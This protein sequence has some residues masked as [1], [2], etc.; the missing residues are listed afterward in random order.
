[1]ELGD[2]IVCNGMCR[3]LASREEQVFWVAKHPNL[4]PIRDMFSDL[5]NVTVVDGGDYL[6]A[7][8]NMV[9]ECTRSICMGYLT[10]LGFSWSVE[11]WD[12]Q[13]YRE[14]GIDFDSRW[15]FFD[16]PDWMK[17]GF[18]KHYPIALV[19]EIPE[20]GYVLDDDKRP[21]IRITQIKQRDSFWDWLPEIFSASELHFVD[22]SFL[23]LAESLY[24]LGFLRSTRLVFH[25][26]AKQRV[27][28]SI[29]PVLRAPWEIL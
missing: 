2:N 29:P 18:I 16:L 22:S 24:A 26:Y 15:K 13:F 1:M 25:R 21:K 11:D 4:L 6:P 8:M 3:V 10:P 19:H 28:H 9:P 14:A 12:R 23:N 20:R 5:P 17:P 27:H 7:R